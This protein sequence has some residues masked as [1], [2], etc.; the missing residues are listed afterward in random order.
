M[1]GRS[2]LAFLVYILGLFALAIWSIHGFITGAPTDDWALMIV[3]PLAWAF[4]YWPIMGSL[5]MVARI[6]GLQRTIEGIASQLESGV[7]PSPENM[8]ELEDIGTELA[9][10]EN[11][12]IHR[13]AGHPQAA[14]PTGKGPSG[15][16]RSGRG[17]EAAGRLTR[18]QAGAKIS[19]GSAMPLS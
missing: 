9:A 10:R 6:R 14:Q 12:R 3:L 4:S 17:Q 15:E 19:C 11:R 16:S 5:F 1:I 7:G 8:K 2:I 18:T 13:P